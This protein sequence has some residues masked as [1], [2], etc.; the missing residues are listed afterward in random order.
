MA[1]TKEELLSRQLHV[2]V[3]YDR[4]TVFIFGEINQ[5]SSYKA[6]VALQALDRDD[7]EIRIILNSDGGGEADGYA[8]Y[9]TILLC[10]NHISID[11]YGSVMSIAAA[12]LQAGDERRVSPN[13]SF[14]IHNGSAPGEETM[15]Q[16]AIMD[17]AKQL[18]KDN[19][20]YY[21]ILATG[22]GQSQKSIEAWC[23]HETEFLSLIHI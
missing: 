14:M 1:I 22:S 5:D 11:G 9:D 7:G 6:I 8:I 2:G 16:N 12:I 21:Q 19:Q 15:Q 17:L 18:E 3:D 4:R 20:R 13:A 10:R 23:R